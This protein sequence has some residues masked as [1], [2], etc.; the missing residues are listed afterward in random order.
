MRRT[1]GIGTLLALSCT[2]Q[3]TFAQGLSLD[4]LIRIGL[5]NNPDLLVAREEVNVAGADTLAAIARNPEL[6]LEAGYNLTNPGSPNASAR[7]SQEFQSGARKGRYQASK[8]SLEAQGQSEQARE[9]DVSLEIRSAYFNGQIL[10]RKKALQ[11]EVGKRWESLARI[12]TAKVKEGRLSQVEEAQAQLNLA[13]AHQKG[14]E[15]QTEI[16]SVEKRLTYLTGLNLAQDSLAPIALDSL[17]APVSLDSLE[18]WALHENADLKTLDKEVEAR[19]RQVKLEQALRTP[20]V[21]LSIGYDRE[22]AGEN[23][24]GGGVSLPLPFFNRNQIGLAKSRASLSLAQSRKNA[25]EIRLAS[26]ISEM[27]GR[28]DQLAQRY[29]AYERDIRTLSRKQLDLSEQGFLQGLLGIFDLSRVQEEF[30]SREMEALDLL[31]AYYGL[32]NRL[33]KAVGGKTW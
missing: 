20:P 5:R 13:K 27:K 17:P 14:L 7:L 28:L 16:E 32:W 8:A 18:A 3:G 22:T 6:G 9:I 21:T 24:I 25:A 4:S 2:I 1:W 33:G 11:V 19:T 26:E 10:M 15:L 31:D 29:Q 12:T 23:L 30:L